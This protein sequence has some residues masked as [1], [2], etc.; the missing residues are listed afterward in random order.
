VDLPPDCMTVLQ[1]SVIGSR[2]DENDESPHTARLQKQFPQARNLTGRPVDYL[3]ARRWRRG[4]PHEQLMIRVINRSS[5]RLLHG[6][7]FLGGLGGIPVAKGR[8]L[9]GSPPFGGEP[10][11][12]LPRIPTSGRVLGHRSPYRSGRVVESQPPTADRQV[13]SRAVPLLGTGRVFGP[14]PSRRAVGEVFCSSKRLWTTDMFSPG[15]TGTG[16]A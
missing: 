1:P 5:A 13:P 16:C 8:A 3:C 12:P 9:S 14:V 7:Q 11:S 10:G 6:A 2:A 4:V 15:R